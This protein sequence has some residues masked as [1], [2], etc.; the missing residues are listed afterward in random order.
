MLVRRG[1][2]QS[3]VPETGAALRTRGDGLAL[4]LPDDIAAAR[5]DCVDAIVLRDI[6]HPI[7]NYGRGLEILLAAHVIDPFGLEPTDIGSRDLPKL[8]M[9]LGVILARI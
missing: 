6:H 5:I 8:R 3:V 2:K 1:N 4:K 7:G 9:P